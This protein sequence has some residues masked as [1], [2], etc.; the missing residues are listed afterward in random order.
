[1]KVPSWQRLAKKLWAN[2]E[3]KCLSILELALSMLREE[4]KLAESEIELNRQLYFCL[5]DASIKLFPDDDIAPIMD[6]NN[7]PDATDEA[8]ARRENKRP[9]FQWIYLD[10]YERDPR[11]SSKQF[12]V[13]CKRLGVALRT[14]WVFNRNY[15]D[16]GISRFCDPD[17]AYGKQAPSGAMLGYWQSMEGSEVLQ[18]VNESCQLCSIPDLLLIGPWSQDG[19]SKLKHE[20]QRP[21]PVSPFKLHHLWIDLRS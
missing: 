10:R 6:A 8:N 7:Q 11:R 5:I 15:V 12:V 21:Y 17:W 20:F 2:R 9:D 4:K 3:A 1:M 19:I 14:D 16:H 13:E 18:E